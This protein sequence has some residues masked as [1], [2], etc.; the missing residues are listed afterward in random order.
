MADF[1]SRVTQA[2]ENFSRLCV[3]IDPSDSELSLWGLP[4]SAAGAKDFGL[5]LVDAASG[6]VGFIKPQVGFFERFGSSGIQALEEVLAEARAAGLFVIADAKRGDIGST[7]L[8]YAQAWFGDDSPLRSDALT[9][10]GYL[11][12]DSLA[13]VA[14]YAFDVQGGLFVL[15]AT[16]NPEAGQLQK[17]KSGARTV[18]GVVLDAAR[19]SKHK[20]IGLVIGATQ[21]LVEFGIEEIQDVDCGV[22]ILAPG[23]GFQ[24]ARLSE[25]ENIFGASAHR[26][27]A[28]M[29]RGLTALGPSKLKEQIEKAKAEL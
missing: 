2:A 8:G 21:D 13:E 29:S 20:N 19:A 22:P 27:I 9:V 28:S 15:C 7:M 14:D 25:I 18:S 12:P 17:A 26:V 6:R 4:D 3:G 23:F 1:V 10:S 16:S 24:G 5:Q 11:G